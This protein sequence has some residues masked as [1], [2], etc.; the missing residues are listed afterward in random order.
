MTD[1][2]KDDT[3]PAAEPSKK[4]SGS[5]FTKEALDEVVK[6]GAETSATALYGVLSPEIKA[7]LQQHSRLLLLGKAIRF[8]VPS[9]TASEFVS[10]FVSNFQKTAAEGKAEPAAPPA[11]QRVEAKAAEEMKIAVAV[12]V[13]VDELGA[14]IQQDFTEWYLDDEANFAGFNRLAQGADKEAIKRLAKRPRVE[15]E[16]LIKQ[17]KGKRKLSYLELRDAIDQDQA[18]T[19][20]VTD[21]LDRLKK[22]GGTDRKREFWTAVERREMAS[23]EEFR[24]MMNLKDEYILHCLKMPNKTP[25]QQAKD[26]LVALQQHMDDKVKQT[27]VLSWAEGLRDKAKAWSEK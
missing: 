17:F 22:A 27:G 14:V 24:S 23:V 5:R 6:I 19:T 10:D 21:F 8:L 16:Q 1:K 3:T 7:W 4:G 20:R 11:P 12:L 9:D 25:S 15:R 18:L 13:A 2:K 26:V